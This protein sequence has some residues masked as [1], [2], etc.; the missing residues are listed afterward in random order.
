MVN[1]TDNWESLYDSSDMT[2]GGAAGVM[3][4]DNAREGDALGSINTQ[5]FGFQLGVDVPTSR[6]QPFT[7]QTR[8]V[9][10]FLGISPQDFQSMGLFI[11]NGDQDN[12][13]KVVTAANAGGG[14]VE[15][16]LEVAGSVTGGDFD[17]SPTLPGP[18]AV[19][20]F[21]IVDP[22]A[23]TAQAAYTTTRLA[24]QS[25]LTPVGTPESIPAAWLD[26]PDF[27]LSVGVISTSRGA[28]PAFP[29]TWDFIAVFDG[30]PGC[31][32]NADCDDSN[33]CTADLCVN[34]TC[35]SFDQPD[36]NTCDDSAACTILDICTS[37][38]CAGIDACS[39]G[40][41]CNL[42]TGMCEG[43]NEDSDADGL[44]DAVDPCPSDARNFCFGPIA[45]DSFARELRVNCNVSSNGCSGTKTD[46]AGDV[47][48]ADFGYN[49]A[50]SAAGCE[51]CD[52]QNVTAL[53]GCEDA[54]TQDL[55]QCEH[56]DNPTGAPLKY[57]FDVP[58]GDYLVNL[59]FAN[60]FSGTENEGDRLFNVDVEGERALTDFDQVAAAGDATETAVVR[61]VLTTVNDNDG[62]SIEFGHVAGKDNP[63][64]KAIEIFAQTPATTTTT[65]TTTSSTTTTLMPDCTGPGDCSDGNDCTKDLCSAGSCSNPPEAFGAPC[66]DGN[67]CTD[68]Q[69]DGDG[70]CASAN[71]NASCD[72]EL[73]CTATSACAG[74]KCSG[75]GD[76]CADGKICDEDT[77]MCQ[78]PPCVEIE[79]PDSVICY[80]NRLCTIPI[81]LTNNGLEVSDAGTTVGSGLEF[82]CG[83]D[84]LEGAAATNGECSLNT[85][86]CELSV[87]DGEGFITPFADGE[88]ARVDIVCTELGTDQFCLS[89]NFAAGPGGAAQ[90]TCTEGCVDFECGSCQ[91][92]DCNQSQSGPN[93]V[94]AGDPVCAVNCLVGSAPAGADCVC[95]ADCNCMGG[96]EASDPICAVLRVIGSFDPDTC[97]QGQIE[98]TSR[99]GDY[100][101]DLRIKKG[102]PKLL[103]D[104]RRSS[105]LISLKGTSADDVAGLRLAL[106]A[107]G[108]IG[109]VRFVRRLK[110]AG[111]HLMQGR[112]GK[113]NIV[114]AAT[115]PIQGDG[116]PAI[117]EGKVLRV[118]LKGG[119][120]DVTI[121]DVQ[122]G[123]KRG[124]PI[125]IAPIVKA[126]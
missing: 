115:P 13:F 52:I 38:T 87:I 34:G 92:G 109:K 29:A 65:T 77:D 94:D 31:T 10:P 111:W 64:I 32:S 63:A 74:G 20:L 86:T 27:G 36:G 14:S 110:K 90:D 26:D 85:E 66:T 3:T 98:A 23:N 46:C 119:T 104:G 30:V 51:S 78:T 47:W 11:G 35:Q 113:G 40:Q 28:A 58:N 71:N 93:P 56:Y 79:A 16:T 62:L 112:P 55:F 95:A 76:P 103:R 68:D 118:R 108:A 80:A 124:L 6:T 73:F 33:Q 61:S 53:F 24:T 69:C 1:G 101:P 88:L 21:L 102:E 54:S 7:V 123:S 75:S 8:I 126:P 48:L 84:C 122:F 125:R 107:E 39:T 91:S 117:D 67:I 25:P 17:A 22:A 43:S 116:V 42:A 37:G 82:D 99:V 81:S 2:A 83:P 89:G 50:A 70:V 15:S 59:F 96:V 72:D 97:D 114:V 4:V 5:M 120:P 9:G 44:L 57:T 18:D 12:Y 41:T 106:T 49:S 121:S 19:D 45:E 60:T 100:A 105:V